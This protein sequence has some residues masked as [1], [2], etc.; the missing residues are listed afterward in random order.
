MPVGVR[1]PVSGEDHTWSLTPVGIRVPVLVPNDDRS[2]SLVSVVVRVS[3][4]DNT[5]SLTPISAP[6]LAHPYITLSKRRS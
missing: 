4:E 1:V 3:G 2:W 6:L 5:W